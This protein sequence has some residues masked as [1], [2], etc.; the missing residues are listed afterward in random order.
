MRKL[1][2]LMALSL[3]LGACATVPQQHVPPKP[4]IVA[5]QSFTVEQYEL[6][7]IEY[8]SPTTVDAIDGTGPADKINSCE[9]AGAAGV[10]Q[11]PQFDKGQKVYVPTC[12]TIMFKGPIKHGVVAIQP[13]PRNARILFWVNESFDFDAQGHFL[14]GNQPQGPFPN[15]SECVAQSVTDIKGA[16]AR[17]VIGPTDSL[18]T[19]CIPIPAYGT[20]A[21]DSQDVEMQAYQKPCPWF[22]FAGAGPCE[23]KAS[24]ELKL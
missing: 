21:N 9:R 1:L 18:V 23:I 10:A 22:P 5:P 13:V 14:K 20:A 11:A 12:L 6:L 4:A 3:F 16:Y 7:M 24:W 19:Y 8:T 17:K 2:A 15:A